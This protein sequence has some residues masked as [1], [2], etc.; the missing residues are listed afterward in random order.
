MHSRF[1]GD[2]VTTSRPFV[3]LCPSLSLDWCYSEGA[4]LLHKPALCHI[5]VGCGPPPPWE[6]G[7]SIKVQLR[8]ELWGSRATPPPPP[9]ALGWVLTSFSSLKTPF[10]LPPVLLCADT[11]VS[12]KSLADW[13]QLISL[14]STLLLCHW[15]LKQSVWFNSQVA[16]GGRGHALSQLRHPFKT[17]GA[18][19]T[20]GMYYVLYLDFMNIFT[21]VVIIKFCGFLPQPLCDLPSQSYLNTFTV[22]YRIVC[23]HRLGLRMMEGL[24]VCCRSGRKRSVLCDVLCFLVLISWCLTALDSLI[25][26]N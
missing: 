17:P 9:Q 1:A 4:W 16:C 5:A 3:P 2:L 13:F 19:A 6:N 14:S 20:L 12:T 10:I 21:C 15:P 8:A 26:F 7:I 22:T 18:E 23:T 11:S 25:P 24:W